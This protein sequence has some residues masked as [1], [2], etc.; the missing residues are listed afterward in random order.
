MNQNDYFELL[1][2]MITS[3]AG[4]EGEP[5]IYGPLRMIEASQRLCRLIL[6]EDPENQN[7]K[8]LIE[9]IENGK[10]K[11]MS[12]EKAFYQ[13]LQDAAAKLVDCI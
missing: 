1:V 12:D 10:G 9:L 4:L 2:Y 7:L 3:A 13:M 5:R 11:T 8:E 6:S